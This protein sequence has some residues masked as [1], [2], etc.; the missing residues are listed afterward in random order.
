MLP[1]AALVALS[2]MPGHSPSALCAR[3][4]VTTAS[5]SRG[6]SAR[7]C[8]ADD[9]DGGPLAGPFWEEL[10]EVADEEAS[11]LGLSVTSISFRKGKLSVLAGGAVG[12][13]T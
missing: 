11:T 9:E 2:F 4:I 6:P 3:Q 13:A 8:L 5:A 7:A 12:C 1:S 10:R